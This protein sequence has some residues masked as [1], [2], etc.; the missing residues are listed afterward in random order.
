MMHVISARCVARDLHT[1][2]PGPLKRMCW[3]QFAAQS[4]DCKKSRIA[5]WS[6]IIIL[7]LIFDRDLNT[8][9]SALEADGLT[10]DEVA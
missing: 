5:P 9:P 6:A 8:E 7:L 3:R 2:A 10:F 4:G 1:I